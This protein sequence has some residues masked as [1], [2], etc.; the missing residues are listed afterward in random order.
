[1]EGEGNEGRKGRAGEDG[2]YIGGGASASW[3]QGG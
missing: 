3:L 1:M 2:N